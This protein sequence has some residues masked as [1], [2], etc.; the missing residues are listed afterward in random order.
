M[1][2]VVERYI[3]HKTEAAS[4]AAF[5][6]IFG[7]MMLLS[8]LRF[9]AKGWIASLY[10][11]P[12]FFFSYY[13]FDW[14]KPI[15]DWTY[16]LFVVCGLSAL[17][18]CL[19]FKYRLSIITFFLSFTYIELMDKTTYLNHYYFVSLVSFIMIWLPAGV[20]F[21]VDS[22]LDKSK[23]YQFV[24]RYTVD[25]IKLMLGIVYFYA[26]L[27]KLNSDWLIDAQPLKIWLSAKYDVPIMGSLMTLKWMPLV[28][29]WIGAVYDL[30]VPFFLI[31][32]KTRPWAY[33]AVIGFHV[34]TAMLFPIGMFPYI[35]ILSTLI[36]F[37]ADFHKRLLNALGKCFG[38]ARECFDSGKT[39]LNTDVKGSQWTVSASILL[40]FFIAQLLLPFRY[41]SYPGELFWTEE[42]FR[43]SWRV[44]L[45]EKTGYVTFKV[46]DDLTKQRYYVQN[47]EF[48]TPFQ[49][50]QMSFQPD[51]IQEFAHY[52]KAYY[53]TNRDMSNVSV[54]ADAYVTLN[55][56]LSQRYLD[57]NIDLTDQD[58]SLK[59]K[60]WILPFGDEI[61]GL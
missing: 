29:S 31:Y 11:E 55:G 7:F 33:L 26:G 60:T 57:P 30:T 27:A 6:V 5:R 16:L 28:M 17:G 25:A 61:K 14:V 47:D 34:M 35:M 21:S 43:F 52:L 1:L 45:V 13:G 19:G 49:E 40:V 37:S 51:M 9:W 10:I 18:V 42:G 8:L 54:Y 15:G 44:M 23:R 22:Y 53:E 41:L 32:R 36:Y 59:H 48:L 38:V 4:L 20:Y 56:R 24:P 3:N 50:K 39:Y 46:V 58:I 12:S 2:S